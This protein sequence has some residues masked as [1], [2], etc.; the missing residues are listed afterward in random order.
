MKNFKLLQCVNLPE[1][2]TPELNDKLGVGI[3]IQ[4]FFFSTL[5][6][7]G[8]EDRIDEYKLKLKD[9]KGI[10]SMHGPALD[11]N[12]ATTDKKILE[13]TKDRYYHGIKMAKMLN[14]K[15]IIFHSQINPILKDPAVKRLLLDKQLTFWKEILPEIEDTDLTILI[16]NFYDNDFKDLLLLIEKINSPKIK[17]LL[18][19]GHVL[20]NSSKGIDYWINGL[21]NHLKYIHFH[22][23]KGNYDAHL[24]PHKE[25]IKEVSNILKKNDINPIISLEYA[26]DDI[27]SEVKKIRAC[28]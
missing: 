10:I 1:K 18:D 17:V 20:C 23:N 2:F 28:D 21:K 3:E 19:T 27:E 24:S 11:L 15:Y 4:D 13:V 26:V 22:Y 25:F 12:P 5:Y 7:E 6:D 14:A 9:F 8:W 16:E